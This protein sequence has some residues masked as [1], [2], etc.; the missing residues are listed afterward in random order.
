[1]Q[2]MI[3]NINLCSSHQKQIWSQQPNVHRQPIKMGGTGLINIHVPLRKHPWVLRE[4][5]AAVIIWVDTSR[6]RH[7]FRNPPEKNSLPVKCF[8]LVTDQLG[9]AAHTSL[10]LSPPLARWGS[11]GCDLQKSCHL[12]TFSFSPHRVTVQPELFLPFRLLRRSE[13]TESHGRPGVHQVP[14]VYLQLSLLGM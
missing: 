8:H 13:S 1:M 5:K 2:L 11:A 10:P 4:P 9:F 14:G 7:S 6:S 3:F 12:P